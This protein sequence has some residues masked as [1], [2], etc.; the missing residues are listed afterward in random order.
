[1]YLW[2]VNKNFCVLQ[3]PMETNI[4]LAEAV[5]KSV[6]DNFIQ[7][8]N[9]VSYIHDD[10]VNDVA[11]RGIRP[12]TEALSV[13]NALMDYFVSPGEAVECQDIAIIHA[14]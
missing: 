5:V 3:K 9:Y 7:K 6:L 12:T 13:R 14:C 4:D 11:T 2:N 10:H 8:E 1:M